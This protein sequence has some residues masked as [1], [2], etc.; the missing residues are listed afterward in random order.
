[1]AHDEEL[2]SR[3]RNSLD[4]LPGLSERRMMGGICFML[5][6]NMIGG[7]HRERTGEGKLLF[8]VGKAQQE[9]A[10]ALPGTV[11]M[12]NG[13]RRMGGFVHAGEAVDDATM[14]ELVS[15]ALAFVT[16]LPPKPGRER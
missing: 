9:A 5:D 1:M 7:A 15:M 16:T 12:V 10:L 13:G 2:A 4:G 14:R 6:G 11:P 8:R 3:M